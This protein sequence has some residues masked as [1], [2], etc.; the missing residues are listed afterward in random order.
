MSPI[1][2]WKR[3]GLSVQH[4]KT[5]ED[6]NDLLET[7]RIDTAELTKNQLKK[8]SN[9]RKL[10]EALGTSSGKNNGGNKKP[11]KRI[12]LPKSERKPPPVKDQLT[13][14]KQF[15]YDKANWKFNKL[16]QN[17]IL[18][19]L[20][21]IPNEYEPELI[22]YLSTLQGGS[23]DRLVDELKQVIEKW[24]VKYEETERKIEE[25]LLNGDN[26]EQEPEEPTQE[27]EEL[28]DEA[29]TDESKEN[30]DEL[31]LEY[32]VRCK[33]ILDS[34]IDGK[35]EVKGHGNEHRT[36]NDNSESSKNNTE[37]ENVGGV[38]DE[39]K[40]EN[41]D[42][43]E[44]NDEIVDPRAE[45]KKDKKRKDKKGKK[46]KKKKSKSKARSESPSE[47]SDTPNLIINEVDV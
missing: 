30:H 7:R 9:K 35:V 43:V 33:A 46:E 17:W 14:L 15:A 27:K 3:A 39:I 34:L 2:A 20:R 12:K 45:G 47:T 42:E 19:N 21:D 23:R 44:D 32:V 41:K 18:K 37:E 40:V 8:V 1:P 4:N 16:K 24:N 29:K 6:E 26:K 13:Y 5:Q 31:N 22:L 11:P 25:R 10:Q 28:K 36:Q 38:G